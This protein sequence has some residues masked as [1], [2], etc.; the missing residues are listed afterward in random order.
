MGSDDCSA[1]T[2]GSK[3]LSNEK[4][5]PQ[6]SCTVGVPTGGNVKIVNRRFIVDEDMGTVVGLVDFG[7]KNG[8][9]DSHTFRLEGG[10]LRYVHTITSCPIENCG[11]PP[12]PPGQIP[13]AG[14]AK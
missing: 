12:Q 11:M 5:D 14:N 8:L 1:I 6:P 3:T 10:K 7:D 9:P 4:N 2:P 13:P